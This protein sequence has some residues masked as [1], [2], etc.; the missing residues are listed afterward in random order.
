MECGKVFLPKAAPWLEDY[1]SVMSTFPA[2]AHDD[3]VDSTTQ[4]LNFMRGSVLTYGLLEA[5]QR[6]AS[7]TERVPGVGTPQVVL[8]VKDPAADPAALQ[9]VRCESTLIQKIPGALRCGNCGFQFGAP[10]L[11]VYDSQRL[12]PARNAWRM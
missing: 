6:I 9:C 2:G 8:G 7:G 1:L 5:M 10:P 11:E 4:A 3:D 12:P